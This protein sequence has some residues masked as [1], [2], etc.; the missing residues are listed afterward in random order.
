MSVYR[1]VTMAYDYVI[2]VRDHSGNKF[3]TEPGD[4]LF[5]RLP[6]LS[7]NAVPVHPLNPNQRMDRERWFKEIMAES[8][9]DFT[10]E[11]KRDPTVFGDVL[12]FLHGYNNSQQIVMQRHALLRKTLREAGY[13]GAVISFDWPSN[14]L[15]LNYLEDRSDAKVTALRLVD[16][17]IERLAEIQ[18]PDCRINVHLLGHST[19]AYVIRE[20]FDDADDRNT[21]GGSDWMVSQIMFIGGD[22]SS[23]CLQNGHP[24]SESLY[25]HCSR[26]T[27]YSNPFDS[28]LKLSNAKRVGMAP[29]VGRVGLPKNASPKAVDVNCGLYYQ[30]LQ[31]K[32]A[33]SYGTFC[34]SWHI[35]DPTFAQ[36]ILQTMYGDIDRL[37]LKTRHVAENGETILTIP[38]NA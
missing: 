20:S 36:D 25:R 28:V 30:T 33:T 37:Y 24:D 29:R 3:G 7:H 34:H 27:N 38:V 15:P 5:L 9:R 8:K 6:E 11:E 4:P 16:C 32:T 17:C 23:A 19:G 12:V 35:G 1:S 14:Q 2:C 26:L 31:E 18:Q 10:R 21:A 22:I 13:G